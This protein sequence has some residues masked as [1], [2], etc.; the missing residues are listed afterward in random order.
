[1][2]TALK[3]VDR[4]NT[5]QMKTAVFFLLWGASAG[6]ALVELEARVVATEER[7]SAHEETISELQRAVHGLEVE[8]SAL[9]SHRDGNGAPAQGARRLT[10]TNNRASIV[11]D[12]SQL[13]LGSNVHV[14]GDLVVNGTVRSTVIAFEAV[15]A[16]PGFEQGSSNSDGVNNPIEFNTLTLDV[17][18]AYDTS[19]YTFTAPLAGYYFMHCHGSGNTLRLFLTVNAVLQQPGAIAYQVDW[20]VV[21]VQ[22]TLQL[23][24]GDTVQCVQNDAAAVNSANNGNYLSGFGG[25]LVATS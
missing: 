16:T 11:Y 5:W 3:Y 6:A 19:T 8:N 15:M 18:G 13:K 9:R 4:E 1:M 2:R 24:A 23:A 22:R 21:N 10:S 12:G 25:F 14:G 20:L 17:G 7:L